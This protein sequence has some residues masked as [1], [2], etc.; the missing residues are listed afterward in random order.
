MKIPIHISYTDRIYQHVNKANEIKLKQIL[1]LILTLI[2]DDWVIQ[3]N[4]EVANHFICL[5]Q[6]NNHAM[7]I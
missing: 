3:L 7:F 4:E 1:I 2:F 6:H 5:A